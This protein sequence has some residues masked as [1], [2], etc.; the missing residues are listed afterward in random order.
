VAWIR[1][2]G[3]PA[4]RRPTDWAWLVVGTVGAVVTGLWAQTQSAIDLNI[5]QPVN[6]LSDFFDGPAKGLLA[7][8]SIVAVGVVT[9]LFVLLRQ[10]RIAVRVGIAGGT[11]WGIAKLLNDVLPTHTVA[12]LHLNV[13]WGDGPA[14]A[15]AHVAAFV[16]MAAAL[17]PYAVRPL[18][19]LLLLVA[20]LVALSAM[21]LGTGYPSDVLGGLF[22]GIA[23]AA[24]VLVV[25]GS[26]AGRPTVDEVRDALGDLG[27]DVGTIEYARQRV[28]RASVVDV[29][30]TSR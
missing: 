2:T 21:Y 26:P 25:F 23:A 13:R 30:L 4:E 20:L 7:L 14:F 10:P 17:A 22:L 16:A 28:P 24:L 12:G 8:G 11:A 29:T 9:L 18:R 3:E 5:Y 6:D 1:N 15:E 19:R 27:Y